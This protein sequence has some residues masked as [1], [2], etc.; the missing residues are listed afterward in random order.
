VSERSRGEAWVVAQF[1]L[2]ALVPVAVFLPPDWPDPARTPRVVLG[3]MMIASGVAVVVWA[4][5]AMGRS[6]TPFPRP[7]PDAVLVETGPYTHVRHPVY[8]GAVVLLVGLSLVTSVAV[9]V[10]TA[11]LGLLWV[12][13]ARV[14]EEHL[15]ELVP[16]YPAYRARV[17][18]RILPGLY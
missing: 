14:E 8:G 3:S 13:K 10:V 15:A 12:G 1:A 11:A 5:R 16:G 18:R 17:P 7:L 9:L 6:M 2:L 4:A